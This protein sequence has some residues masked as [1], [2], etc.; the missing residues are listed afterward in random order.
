M[1]QWQSIELLV[2][3]TQISTN[4]ALSDLVVAEH[5]ATIVLHSSYFGLLELQ[6]VSSLVT[7][8]GSRLAVT[9]RPAMQL[10]S[11]LP[12]SGIVVHGYLCTWQQTRIADKSP[13]HKEH[14]ITEQRTGCR[15]VLDCSL[16]L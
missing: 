6:P 15:N 9:M 13:Q 11:Q 8:L 16:G 3:T 5:E 2:T 4:A 1:L 14:G 12:R 10:H 7:A